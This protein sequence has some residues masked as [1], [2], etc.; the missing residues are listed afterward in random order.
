MSPNCGNGRG[1]E[2][3]LSVTAVNGRESK[4]CVTIIFRFSPALALGMSERIRQTS[5]P[6]EMCQIYQRRK[7]C[8]TSRKQFENIFFFDKIDVFR[9]SKIHFENGSLGGASNKFGPR[10]LQT[11]S[12]HGRP[13]PLQTISAHR[14]SRPLQAIQLTAVHGRYKQFRPT[15]FFKIGRLRQATCHVF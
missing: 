6:R 13:W 9:I 12:A 1:R 5:S 4:L 8:Q 15:G 7:C 10:P 2:P 3:K 14:R 11:I